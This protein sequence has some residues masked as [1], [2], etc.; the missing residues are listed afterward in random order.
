MKLNFVGDTPR[1]IQTYAGA[2]YPREN[3]D[4]EELLTSELVD[5]V[6]EIFQTP[7]SGSYNWD[8]TLQDDRIKKL[9]DLE[10]PVWYIKKLSNGIKIAGVSV[11]P[12]S[13]VKTKSAQLLC[14]TDYINWY[15][16]LSNLYI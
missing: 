6:A 14:S 5:H 2:D 16:L 4:L 13:S 12:G 3:P 1:K 11:E 7:L 15:K 9:Y 10:G 8:Y